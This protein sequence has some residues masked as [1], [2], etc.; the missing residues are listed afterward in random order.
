MQEKT[1]D[2]ICGYIFTSFDVHVILFFIKQTEKFS[3][4]FPESLPL[5]FQENHYIKPFLYFFIFFV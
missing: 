3:I 4:K 1:A 2:K 5:N